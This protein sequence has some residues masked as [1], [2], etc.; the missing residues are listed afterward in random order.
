MQTIS[1]DSNTNYDKLFLGYRLPEMGDQSQK[2]KGMEICNILD[3]HNA[4]M[5]QLQAEGNEGKRRV[6]N[7]V[8][9]KV[10]LGPR[11]FYYD[12]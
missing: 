10:K 8:R 1:D 6:K 9:K 2:A 3:E 7:S 4:K 11:G 5:Q 12:I